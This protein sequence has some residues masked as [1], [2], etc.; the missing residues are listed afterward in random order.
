MELFGSY[1]RAE[2]AKQGL[3]SADG[4]ADAPKLTFYADSDERTLETAK[5]LAQGLMPGCD[6]PV[7]SRPQ[8]TNDPLFHPLPDPRAKDATARARAAIAGRIGG[9]PANV[10]L[11]Y[12]EQIAMLD[13]I[14]AT[15]GTAP[16]TE[17][18]RTSLFDIPASL[19]EGTGDHLAEMKGPINTAST[20]SEN[21]LLEY[22]EGMDSANVGWGCVRREEIQALMALHTAATDFTQ[23]TPEIA[24]AQAA[25]L[26]HQID[27][28]IE[29]AA[30]RKAVSGALG[31]PD[32]RA[33]FLIGHDTNIENIA[34]A[35]NLTWIVDGRRD[36]TP[37]GGAL[38]FELWRNTTSGA[39]TVR[40][41]FMAQT[42]EQMRMSS[43]L[44][45]KNPPDRV[46]VFLP[47]CSTTDMSCPL[48]S[49]SKLIP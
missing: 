41:Y 7:R 8:G 45:L 43:D 13:H 16:S 26:L 19:S 28:S 1:D 36:D 47:G 34:G 35:L 3:L 42:L 49:F 25:N 14:L 27:L 15:C 30:Q 10:S 12:R 17:T 5:S 31:K 18:K 20:L 24:K 11:A 38:V 4:C 6:V 23:R 44:T 33:L 39:Y 29:Q 37:P 21:L 32:D 22:T 48:P 46:E 9:D 40:T 2:F